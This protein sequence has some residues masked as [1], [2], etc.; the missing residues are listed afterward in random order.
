M[1]I[2]ELEKFDPSDS[3]DIVETTFELRVALTD[4]QY[5]EVIKDINE[6][7][8]ARYGEEFEA[9]C[10]TVEAYVKVRTCDNVT[11]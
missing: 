4:E 11:E 2:L 7:E 5:T 10:Y 3:D 8:T 6:M 1:S 9:E